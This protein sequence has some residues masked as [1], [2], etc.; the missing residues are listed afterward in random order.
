MINPKGP[1]YW[2]QGLFLQPEHFQQSN[3]YTESLLS[4]LQNYMRPY[5]W[6]ACSLSIDTGALKQYTFRLNDG[7]FLFKDGTWVA[8]NQNAILKPRSFKGD[9]E[10][11]HEPFVVYVAIKTLELQGEQLDLQ[12]NPQSQGAKSRFKINIDANEVPDLYNRNHKAPVSSLNYVLEFIWEK[13]IEFYPDYEIIPIAKVEFNGQEVVCSQDF[14]P[15]VVNVRY[16]PL[17]MLYLKNMK[18]ALYARSLNLGAIQS[19]SNAEKSTYVLKYLTVLRVVNHYVPLLNHYYETPDISP[20]VL[21]GIFRQLVGEL[22]FL[23]SKLDVLGRNPAGDFVIPAYDHSNLGYCFGQVNMFI[24][25]ILDELLNT[26]ET[27]IHLRKIGD[28]YSAEIPR[29]LLKDSNQFYLAIKNANARPDLL[30]ST[31]RSLKIGSRETIENLRR[32]AL[33]GVSLEVLSEAPVGTSAKHN[34][35]YFRLDNRNISWGSIKDNANICIFSLEEIN[36][37]EIDLCILKG[38]EMLT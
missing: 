17:L 2:H 16:S 35:T 28:Y 25:E 5:F 36:D 14:I 7:E 34:V 31:M 18:D 38:R 22:S 3:L 23:S 11:F 21:Y 4:P 12:D 20:W 13:E 24:N 27:I 26:L 32:R 8:I 1:I 10:K 30:L 15:T 33:S 19:T 9:W 29:E 6:G 37:V